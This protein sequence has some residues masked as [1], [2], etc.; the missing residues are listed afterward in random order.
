LPALVIPWWDLKNQKLMQVTLPAVTLD[1]APAPPSGADAVASASKVAGRQWLWWTVGTVLLLT[2]AVATIWR[3]REML[4]A[5]WELRQ[6]KRYASET[7]SFARLLEACRAGNAKV[8]YNELLHWLEST[9][10]GTDSATIEAFLVGHPDADLQLQ[11]EALQEFILGRATH[12]NGPALADAL[13]WACQQH[14]RQRT[15]KDKARLPA[16]NPP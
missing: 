5:P 14:I 9:H 6:A 12:W 4:L 15:T 11:V 7:G 1:A 16:L 10:R 13:R 8:A 3:R 2:V